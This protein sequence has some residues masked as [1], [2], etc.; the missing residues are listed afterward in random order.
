MSCLISSAAS[1]HSAALPSSPP[2][3]AIFAPRSTRDPAHDLR[4]REVLR[5]A[6][7]LPD[8][9]VG[10]A[11]VLERLA[12]LAV[13]DRPDPVV[14]VVGRLRVQV[15]RVE[16]GAPHVVLASASTPRCRCAPGREFGVAGQVVE[17]ELLEL[18]LAA[19]AVH[20]LEVLVA[21]RHVGDEREEVDGL[22]VEAEGV[23][24][25]QR[26]R[27]VADPGV[28]V[29]VVA[30]AARGLGQRRAAG[31]GHRAGRRVGQ[32]LE[33]Q[34]AALQVAAP[35]VVGEPAARQPVLPVV[36]GPDQPLVG[37]VVRR[38]RLGPAPRQRDEPDV[39]LLEQRAADRRGRPRSRAACRWSASGG[40]RRRRRWPSPGGSSSPVYSQLRG[41]TGRSRRPARSPS[42]SAPRPRRSGWCAAGCARPRS[43][44]A[45]G[46]RSPSGRPAWCHGPISSTSRMM[47]QPVGVPQLV[48]RIIVPGR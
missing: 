20:D 16:Q 33:G 13:E 45:S 31:R 17:L 26:E 46:G 29:V 38:G 15:H 14:E 8:A 9:G 12:D 41:A 18:A 34:R 23:H 27:R 21:A 4:R 2:I 39:A 7:H 28:A 22:P 11:P 5:L 36:G 25:P 37:V 44:W 24:R 40:R 42:P 19:D 32:A 6:A 30:V 47:I 35:G 48:S 10:L 1:S 43:R 3:R